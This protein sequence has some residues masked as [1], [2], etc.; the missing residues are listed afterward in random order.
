MATNDQR[1]ASR[2]RER[3]LF[4][5]ALSDAAGLERRS[6]GPSELPIGAI[7]GYEVTRFIAG[8]GQGVVYE[9]RHKASQ[10][11]VAIKFLRSGFLSTPAER[12][13]F[14]REIELVARLRHPGIVVI[15]DSGEVRGGA[16]GS[17]CYHV[18]DFIDGVP[19]DQWWNQSDRTIN[20]K[21]LVFA[22]ICDAV[23]A[24]HLRGVI[25][26]DLK[27]SN[28]LI[29]ASDE[30]RVLDFGLAT[31]SDAGADRP[32]LTLTG[33]FVGSLPWASPEQASE[34]MSGLDLRSDVYSLGVVLCQVATGAFPYPT[35]GSMRDIVGH[36]CGTTPKLATAAHP[37]LAAIVLRCLAKEREL[38]YQSAGD[39]ALDVRRF[40]AGEPIEARRDSAWYVLTK[41]LRR[42]RVAASVAL[43]FALL[44]MGSTAVMTYL[45][46]DATQQAGIARAERDRVAS[47]LATIQGVIENVDVLSSSTDHVDELEAAERRINGTWKQDPLM[48]A[49][50]R[51]ALAV[52]YG[53][54]CNRNPRV[55]VLGVA[56][57]VAAIDRLEL[58]DV[59]ESLHLRFRLEFQRRY[60]LSMI[61]S[62]AA[63]LAVSAVALEKARTSPEMRIDDLVTAYTIH[64][65]D[66]AT[67][68]RG[69]EMERLMDEAVA[70][71][72]ARTSSTSM[73]ATSVR[74]FRLNLIA[75]NLD[76]TRA[77]N[78]GR[79]WYEDVSRIAP[80]DLE[81]RNSILYTLA[82][83]YTRAGRVEDLQR[84][85]AESK[86]LSDEIIRD[87][88]KAVHAIEGWTN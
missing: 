64:A 82:F 38:R 60:V 19:F 34:S 41:T 75:F 4:A 45:Y 10:R 50:I 84:C 12:A 44:L 6:T 39:I 29:D 16:L 47:G 24:A 20:S 77:I 35:Q 67:A 8:G 43:L 85:Q 23:H 11:R 9:G 5:D 32:E 42:Y 68:G 26:R 54:A 73:T 2:S 48:E 70:L 62:N 86:E 1:D 56:R 58:P 61:E 51:Y 57:Q 76:L 31:T 30:P 81:R 69:T 40:L 46:R 14:D 53:A 13:R 52:G 37:D 17:G 83:F 59:A 63:A 66:L 21:L 27:P 3:Q 18:M 80:T 22:K 79:A 36:I 55:G 71:I 65:G 25:H 33:Q 74:Q 15:Q 28:V 49:R 78:K 87:A 88:R 7:P 72:D